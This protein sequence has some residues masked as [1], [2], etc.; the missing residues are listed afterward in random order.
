MSS[1]SQIRNSVN[2]VLNDFSMGRID[3]SDATDAIDSIFLVEEWDHHEGEQLRIESL[4]DRE[5]RIIGEWLIKERNH[6]VY[7]NNRIRLIRELREVFPGLSLLA[8][9]YLVMGK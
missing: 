3:F 8:C 9:K 2:S 4:T 5:F 1:I 6:V 7:R